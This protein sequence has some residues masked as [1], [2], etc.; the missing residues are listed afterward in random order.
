M[1]A[2]AKTLLV[3]EPSVRLAPKV[4]R[5]LEESGF[6]VVRGVPS[7]FHVIGNHPAPSD[8]LVLSVALKTIENCTAEGTSGNNVRWQFARNLAIALGY[9]DT[10]KL[11]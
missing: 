7:D 10:V 8:P 2:E 11:K 5:A 6:L 3:I 1:S 4:L 9:A